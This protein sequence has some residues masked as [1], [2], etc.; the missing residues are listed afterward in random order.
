MLVSKIETPL[1]I[2]Y[3]TF[4]FIKGCQLSMY[5]IYVKI[6][7]LHLDVCLPKNLNFHISHYYINFHGPKLHYITL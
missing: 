3:G 5:Y 2:F 7:F 1:F 6:I 4:K